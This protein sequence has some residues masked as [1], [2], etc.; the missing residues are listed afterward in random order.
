MKRIAYALALA[1]SLLASVRGQGLNTDNTWTNNNRFKGP[2]PFIDVT[3]YG[4]K[5][6]GSTDDTTAI[7]NAIA[8][9]S[10][11]VGGSIYFPCGTYKVSSSLAFATSS[12]LN[13][14]ALIGANMDCAIIEQSATNTI[15]V[16]IGPGGSPVNYRIRDITIRCKTSVTCGTGLRIQGANEFMVDHVRVNEHGACGAFIKDVITST[17]VHLYITNN[18]GTCGGLT[19]GGGLVLQ[20]TTNN[21]TFV[22]GRI[23]ANAGPGLHA[24][25][26]QLNAF[27][28]TDFEANT[29]GGILVD[30]ATNQPILCY[31]CWV[32]SNTGAVAQ[33]VVTGGALNTVF[34]HPLFSAGGGFDIQVDNARGTI[35]RDAG[36]QS[37]NTVGL[38]ITS[39]A[40]G[41][42]VENFSRPQTGFANLPMNLHDAGTGTFVLADTDYNNGLHRRSSPMLSDGSFADSYGGF[43]PSRTNAYPFGG[44]DTVNVSTAGTNPPTVTQDSSQ[45][46]S[47]PPSMKVV[48]PSSSSSSEARLTDQFSVTSGQSVWISFKAMAS[49]PI[50]YLVGVR[51]QDGAVGTIAGTST[52]YVST[53]WRYY[54]FNIPANFTDSVAQ[55]HFVLTGGL[56]AGTTMWIDDLQVEVNASSPSAFIPTKGSAFTSIVGLVAP[57]VTTA[58]LTNTGHV[59]Q[60]AAN[61]DLAGTVTLSGGSA[62]K[63]FGTVYSSAPVC[64]ASDQTAA[65]AVKVTTTTTTATF[66]GTGTHVVAYVC[67]GNPN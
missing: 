32:E 5:G 33:V 19:T 40:V 7:Q 10:G 54:A 25:G 38:S 42:V 65:N 50:D 17:F 8:S 18:S 44:F 12:T 61:G 47:A 64:V 56:G 35:I 46:F 31:A 37:G 60:G 20:G 23:S 34:D 2:V 53:T 28:G 55:V 11:S 62:T 49:A 48:W 57:G 58:Q 59:N 13:N 29:N 6:D 22:G 39:N 16:D 1:I 41:T 45:E 3:A 24:N 66:T 30:A 27:Y 26:G 9:L 21:N 14:V 67:I 63:T 43:G 36:L 4:A 51:L 15:S 52:F